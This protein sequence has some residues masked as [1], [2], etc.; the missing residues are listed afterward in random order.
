MLQFA[1]YVKQVGLTVK[2]NFIGKVSDVYGSTRASSAAHRKPIEM[3]VIHTTANTAPAVNE[4]ANL[5][6]NN[7][8]NSFNAV[9]DAKEVYETVR[10]G[11]VSHHAG[12]KD[13]NQRSIGVE[14]VEMDI[15]QGYVNLVKYLGYAMAQLGLYPSTETV[16]LHSEFVQTSCGSFYKRKGMNAIVNDII[17]YYNIALNGTSEEVKPTPK[18]EPTVKTNEQIA[19]EV[20]RGDWGNGDDRFNRLTN[21][22]YDYYAIQDIINGGVAPTKSVDDVAHSVI[23]GDYG[24]GQARYDKLRA[25]G[26]DADEV[27][28]RVNEILG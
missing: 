19:A 11:D 17:K 1:D 12:D 9:A 20:M 28:S 6:N 26:Y 8:T 13:I 21:A 24:N 4:A 14:L 18:P 7:G 10:F 16:R 27:Q 22:G 3:V 25:E 5:A 15:E 23:R 2:Q